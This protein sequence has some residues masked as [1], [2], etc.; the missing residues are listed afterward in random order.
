LGQEV[1]RAVQRW[2]TKRTASWQQ[3]FAWQRRRPVGPFFQGPDRGGFLCSADAGG[4]PSRS[5]GAAAL[6]KPAVKR[7]LRFL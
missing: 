1:I 4:Y 7:G 6:R 3:V 5:S 2:T